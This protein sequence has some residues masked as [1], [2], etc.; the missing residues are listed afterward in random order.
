VGRKSLARQRRAQ[1]VEAFYRCIVRDGLQKASTREVAKEAGV[2]A[3][4]LHHYFKDRDEMIEELVKNIVD[5]ISTRYVTE[6]GRYKNPRT[7]FNKA[8]E[9]LFGP[10]MINEEHAGFFYDCWAEAKRN[11]KVRESFAKLYRRFHRTIVDLLV[12]TGLASGLS[13]A[14]VSELASMVIAIQDG[15]SLQWEIDPQSV[16]LKNMSRLTKRLIELYIEKT[17]RRR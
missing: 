3:S 13:H 5:E 10:A 1:I 2:Q 16:S 6:I 8:I 11:E 14:E 4:I 17:D 15:I 7:R 9:F 12:E